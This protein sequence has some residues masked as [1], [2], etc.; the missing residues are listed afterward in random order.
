MITVTIL[1]IAIHKYLNI[2]QY[3]IKQIVSLFQDNTKN[4][5]CWLSGPVCACLSAHDNSSGFLSELGTWGIE[6]FQ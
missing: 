5:E 3:A 2:L 1:C 4:Y 6:F